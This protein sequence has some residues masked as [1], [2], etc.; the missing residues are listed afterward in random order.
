MADETGCQRA[1]DTL[2]RRIAAGCYPTALPSKAIVV[3]AAR[4]AL[5]S[6]RNVVLVSLNPLRFAKR[7]ISVLLGTNDVFTACFLILAERLCRVSREICSSG[8]RSWS[9]G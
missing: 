9:T 5:T 4:L 1:H 6:T 3:S 2:V 7:Y 8:W